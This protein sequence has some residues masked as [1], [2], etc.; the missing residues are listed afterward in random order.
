MNSSFFWCMALTVLTSNVNG[1][2]DPQ[3]W[4]DIW[5]ALPRSDIRCLQEIHLTQEQEY[6]FQLHAQSYSYWYLHGLSNLAGVCV[7]VHQSV[8]VN[9]NRVGEY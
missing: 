8:G 5:S 7:C 3:K 2:H 9:I 6:A 4:S 1:M